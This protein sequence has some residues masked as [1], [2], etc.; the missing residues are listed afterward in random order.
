MVA[1]SIN[2]HLQPRARS[3]WPKL[4][5]RPPTSVRLRN[6]R[7]LPARTG[8]VSPKSGTQTSLVKVSILTASVLML[9][10]PAMACT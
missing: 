9:A 6:G 8:K 3:V 2:S 10:V 1:F 7:K 5:I 4:A